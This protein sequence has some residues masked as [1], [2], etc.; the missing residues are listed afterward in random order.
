MNC[1][2]LPDCRQSVTRLFLPLILL[3]APGLS[4]ASWGQKKVYILNRGDHTLLSRPLDAIGGALNT[5]TKEGLANP[6]DM[7]YDPVSNTLLWS[8][9]LNNR[10]VQANLADPAAQ[11][12]SN[13]KVSSPVDL[14]IDPV[15]QQLYWVD[16]TE[17]RLMRAGMDGNGQE[18]VP[19]E[20]LSNPSSIALF[21]E[22]DLLFYADIDQ[23][24]IWSA[25]LSGDN[26]KVIV[27][28]DIDYPVRLL[29]DKAH[30]HLYWTDDGNHVIER[31]NFDGSQRK[32]FYQ[33]TNSE[34]PFGLYLDE[35]EGQLYWTDY[36][37]EKIMRADVQNPATAE[38]FESGLDDPLALL[39]TPMP[40]EFGPGLADRQSQLPERPRLGL[41]P[42]PAD[43]LVTFA[44]LLNGAPIERLR[45]FD[46]LGKEVFNQAIGD[47]VFQLDI[48]NFP[49]GYYSYNARV[50][51]TFLTGHFSIVH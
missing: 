12:F 1:H 34:Y 19:A 18:V 40:P 32:V 47:S 37:E 25:S 6:Y 46:S 49:E 20:E 24:R 14:D 15:N 44:S 30:G 27:E 17:R 35:T 38:I 8:D 13:A 36:G 10:I 31:V 9:G 21:P 41:Y 33:G 3:F 48:R 7:V 11:V 23:K 50:A 51:G 5:E 16:N 4:N 45:V 39:L 43:R 28:K 29:V 2:F 22:L 42:N 26:A